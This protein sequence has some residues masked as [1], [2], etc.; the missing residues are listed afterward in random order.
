MQWTHKQAVVNGEKSN[1]CAC[2]KIESTRRL[3]AS[4]RRCSVVQKPYLQVVLVI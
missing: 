3:Y 4:V 2:C 1:V